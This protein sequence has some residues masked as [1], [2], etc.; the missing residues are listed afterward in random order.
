MSQQ[1]SKL[2]K[3]KNPLKNKTLEIKGSFWFFVFSFTHNKGKVD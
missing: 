2:R 3:L 1:K